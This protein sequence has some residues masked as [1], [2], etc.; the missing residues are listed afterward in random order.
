VIANAQL[1]LTAQ[2]QQAMQQDMAN[3]IAAAHQLG[4]L[5]NTTQQLGLGDVNALS[6]LGQQQQTIAQNEQLF[7]MQQLANQSALLRGYTIPTSVSASQ[8]GPGQQGQFQT[9]PLQQIMSVGT[10]LG[11]LAKPGVGGTSAGGNLYSGLESVIKRIAGGG[12][13]TTSGSTGINSTLNPVTGLPNGVPLG[14]TYNPTDNT[15]SDATGNKY[16]VDD[17]GSVTSYFPTTNVDT[18]GY[19]T[20]DDFDSTIQDN[21][22]FNSNAI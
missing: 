1:G 8:T 16:L 21:Y 9:S 4:T 2:Q 13:G 12:S 17:S 7:P 15:Y 10:L 11:A 3:R 14:A 22:D 6:T 19:P 18:G 20:V 5:A